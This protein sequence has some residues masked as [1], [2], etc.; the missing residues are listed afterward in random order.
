M[1][2]EVQ[3]RNAI[4][5]SGRGAVLIG[6]VRGGTPRVGQLTRPLSLGLESERRLEVTAVETL[7]SAEAGGPA[8]GLVFRNPPKLGDLR[9]ALPAGTILILEDSDPA[10]DSDA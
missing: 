8:V 3:V 9:R 2:T 5:I 4:S 7:H 6:Y 1:H 10:G